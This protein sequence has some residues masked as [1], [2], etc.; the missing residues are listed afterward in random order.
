LERGDSSAVGRCRAVT[1][2]SRNKLEK[3]LHLF[4]D[5]FELYDDARTDKLGI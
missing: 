2:T 1:V 3:F 4:G 5:L